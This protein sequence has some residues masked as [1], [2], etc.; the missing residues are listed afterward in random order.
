[1]Q[2]LNCR[3]AS[4]RCRRCMWEW[5]VAARSSTFIKPRSLLH[6]QHAATRFAKLDLPPFDKGL[7]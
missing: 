1:L 2:G 5:T 7:M 6:S 3:R 4:I